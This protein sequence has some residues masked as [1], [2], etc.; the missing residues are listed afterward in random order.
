L[1]R[2]CSILLLALFA[3]LPPQSAGAQIYVTISPPPDIRAELPAYVASG[4]HRLQFYNGTSRLAKFLSMELLFVDQ[5]DNATNCENFFGDVI[6][7][8]VRKYDL[9]NF[10]VRS[11]TTGTVAAKLLPPAAAAKDRLEPDPANAAAPRVTFIAC[12]RFKYEFD[13]SELEINAFAGRWIFDRKTGKLLSKN[14]ATRAE[15]LR[16][17]RL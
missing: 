2:Y 6:G 15:I 11:Q 17:T 13:G 9:N 8:V 12:Y 4:E 5:S 14:V 3:A 1:Y 7:P 10:E 16:V